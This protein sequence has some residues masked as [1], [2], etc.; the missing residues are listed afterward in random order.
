MRRPYSSY[1]GEKYNLLKIIEYHKIGKG[2]F[3][4]ECDCGNTKNVRCDHVLSGRTISCGC[5]LN[6]ERWVDLTGRRFNK[7]IVVE[8]AYKNGYFVYWRCKC[9]CGN[10]TIVYSGNLTGGVTRS[11]G[12]YNKERIKEANVTH[13]DSD[14]RLYSIYLGMKNRCYNKNEPAYNRYGGRGIKVCDE[15][16]EKG[17]GFVSF[18]QWALKNGYSDKLTIDRIDVNGNY[19][20]SNCRWADIYTQANNKRSNRYFIYN[21]VKKS[22]AEWSKDLGISYSVIQYGLSKHKPLKE[23][24]GID[25]KEAL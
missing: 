18:K 22:M 24:F 9:D 20:P 2:Y 14:T 17:T 19:E 23:V 12:C 6:P 10:E 25:I 21:G 3:T 13:G 11:C 16:R 15:W 4:C 8:K 7:L 5:K 1:I